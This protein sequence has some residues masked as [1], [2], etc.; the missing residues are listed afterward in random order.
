MVVY[1]SDMKYRGGQGKAG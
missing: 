1:A